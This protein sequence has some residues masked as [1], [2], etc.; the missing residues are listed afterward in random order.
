MAHLSLSCL[1]PLQVEL[2]GQPVTDFKSNKVRAL[3]SYL[4]V[5]ADRPHHRE[6][7]AGLLWPDWPDRDA[8]SN[9]RYSLSNLRRVI[10]DQSAAPPYLH[11]TRET[12]QFNISSDHWIDVAAFRELTESQPDAAVESQGLDRV[13][14]AVRLFRGDFLEGFSIS[15]SIGFEEWV[16]LKRRQLTQMLSSSFRYLILSFEQ[17]GEFEQAQNYARKQIEIEPWD[18]LAHQQLMRSLAL[19]G[20]RGAALVQFELC[21]HLLAEE[22]DVDPTLET[23]QL[24]EQIRTGKLH[25]QD[26]PPVSPIE[27]EIACPAFLVEKEPQIDIPVFVAREFEL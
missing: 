4:A 20:Q 3:L 1:G 15:D 11:I 22:L 13:E 19:S 27:A 18:E 23:K 6:V 7:L 5:E 21:R 26:A 2:D 24:H 12:L 14:E 16:E 25:A 8:L 10:D 9:L 17:R